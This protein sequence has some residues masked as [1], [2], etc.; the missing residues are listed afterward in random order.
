M[1]K[2]TYLLLLLCL[3][4]LPLQ[5]QNLLQYEWEENRKQHTLTAK[6]QEE[7]AIALLNRQSYE[8]AVDEEKGA[9]KQ[10]T[11]THRIVKVNTDNAIEQ[12]NRIY[13]PLH[14][15][16]SIL[17]L[18]ARSIS[19]DGKVTEV[20]K[21]NIKEIKDDDSQGAYRIFALE[22]V[23][24]GSEIEYYYLEE[25][26]LGFF[27]RAYFQSAIPCR[28]A[29][30]T[31]ECPSFIQFDARSYNG[32]SS[33]VETITDGMRVLA[34]EHSNIPALRKQEF[35]KYNANRQRIEF[36][37]N[38]N[39]RYSADPIFTWSDA[40]GYINNQ[41]YQLEAKED[42]AAQKLYKSLKIDASLTPKEKIHKIENHL[43]TNFLIQKGLGSGKLEEIIKGGYGSELGLV[44]L[45][46]SLFKLAGVS[47]EVG[48]TSSRENI[49]F[50]PEFSSWNYLE[51]YLFYFPALDMY[52]APEDMMYRFP[53]IPYDNTF[54]SGLFFNQAAAIGANGKQPYT[55]RQISTP[56]YKANF[57]NM[58]IQLKLTPALD[59]VLLQV[60]QEYGGYS[61]AYLQPAYALMPKEQREEMVQSL[62][63]FAA[64]DAQ[65]EKYNITGG[66]PNTNVLEKPFV[67]DASLNSTALLERAGNKYLLKVGQ[68]IGPQSELYQEEVRTLT[69]ENEFNRMYDRTIRIEL[70]EG[71][72]VK[73]PEDIRINKIFKQNNAETPHCL[74]TSDYKQT[75]NMLE[76][77]IEEFY[78]EIECDL[79]N[80]EKFRE[81][82]NAAADFN[83]VTLVLEKGK[84]N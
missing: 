12:H 81:V 17:Q 78:N 83:K 40:I 80:Y 61:A 68:V 15:T 2:Y 30:F 58:D 60:R 34:A 59:K 56:G 36:R 54:N 18:K 5:A 19:P 20:D 51:T 74:F 65:I 1:N 7:P 39:L 75:G 28:K 41:V 47:H 11:L 73:N 3:V 32:F 29:V 31:L 50:D 82:V 43:K 77:T 21:N 66:E 42:K 25:N 49:R 79:E 38:K 9:L 8:Y 6:E 10:Y 37:L 57:H 67:I 72:V 45:Y 55:I 76:I 70:P 24:K 44:R 13:I 69:V 62:I 52:L 53:L 27:G 46:A 33:P 14:N 23:V 16:E 35:A 22:G 64:P 84:A 71:Y 4:Q 26:S 63:K 48:L